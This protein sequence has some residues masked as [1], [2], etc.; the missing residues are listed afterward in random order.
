LRYNEQAIEI[1]KTIQNPLE[2]LRHLG[3][4]AEIRL[5]EGKD[6]EVP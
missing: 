4:M 6:K 1:A 2:I 3:Y 5:R